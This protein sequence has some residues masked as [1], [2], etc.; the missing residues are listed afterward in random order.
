MTPLDLLLRRY[1]QQAGPIRLGQ[2]LE[3]ALQHPVHGYYR[4]V[5]AIGSEHDFITAPEISGLFG[6]SIALWL[7]ARWQRLGAAST[8]HLIEL[9]PG[10]G[11]L[12]ADI[13]A[14][15]GR[16]APDFLSC[17]QIH[18]VESNQ[19]L[20][21][22]QQQRL[23]SYPGVIWHDRWDLLPQLDAEGA[24][25]VWLIANEFLDALPADQ[26][27]YQQGVWYDRLLD[28]NPN[29]DLVFVAR[30]TDPLKT[31]ALSAA[32]GD[33]P[34][35]GM[36]EISSARTLLL[37]EVAKMIDRNGGA[38]LWIDYG[39]PQPSWQSSLQAYHRHQV[40]DPL[41]QVGERDLSVGVNWHEA[42][43]AVQAVQLDLQATLLS[44]HDFLIQQGIHQL[45][46]QLPTA[47]QQQEQ[48]GL[49]RLLDREGMGEKFQVL[50]L[51]KLGGQQG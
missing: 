19:H 8:H 14:S 38:A 47:G 10:R 39:A 5:P 9:G 18:L 25:P 6:Q 50:S 29:N 31:Q 13:I 46:A 30:P 36:V 42:L 35:G 51:E 44:Q 43:T 26:M 4:Q 21:A 22:Q 45:F 20:R 3:I 1:I 49:D 7:V 24:E 27:L 33:C 15:L 23:S 16:L 41:Q 2:F 28:L 17:C 37:Q 40:V 32:Y 34:D 12:M 11:V 48:A